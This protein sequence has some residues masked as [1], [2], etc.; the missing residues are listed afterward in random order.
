MKKSL[1]TPQ[2]VVIYDCW[3]I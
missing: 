3:K 2:A 1:V